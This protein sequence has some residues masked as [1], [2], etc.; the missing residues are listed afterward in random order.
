MLCD[1]DAEICLGANVMHS[2]YLNVDFPISRASATHSLPA[3]CT[4]VHGMPATAS[5]HFRSLLVAAMPAPPR[6]PHAIA[7]DDHSHGYL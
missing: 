4:F 2:K 6:R 1:L 7:F 3:G 5:I